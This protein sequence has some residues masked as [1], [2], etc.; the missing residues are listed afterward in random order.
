MVFV[1]KTETNKVV[2]GR[3]HVQMNVDAWVEKMRIYDA[4]NI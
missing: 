2:D 1:A 4:T 3:K